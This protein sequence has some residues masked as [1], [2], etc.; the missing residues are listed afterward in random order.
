[1]RRLWYILSN[2]LEKFN[3][4]DILIAAFL[5]SFGNLFHKP[6]H[7]AV[8][9]KN[10][11]AKAVLFWTQSVLL[12]CEVPDGREDDNCVPSLFRGCL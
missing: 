4:E 1:M 12:L 11:S 6:L 9:H 10:V 2:A 3:N 7:T 8:I 5:H